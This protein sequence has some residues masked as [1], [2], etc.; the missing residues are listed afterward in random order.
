M[1]NSILSFDRGVTK[2]TKLF[3]F[4]DK[5]QTIFWQREADGPEGGST[6]R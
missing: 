4:P 6:I 2:L 1:N 3:L 5:E